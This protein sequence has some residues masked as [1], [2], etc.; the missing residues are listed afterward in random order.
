MA[1]SAIQE[2]TNN[3]NARLAGTDLCNK[4]NEDAG[5]YELVHRLMNS[6]RTRYLDRRSDAYISCFCEKDD[7]LSQW[8]GYSS[9]GGYSI[10]I[11]PKRLKL[12]AIQHSKDMGIEASNVELRFVEYDHAS[13]L[14]RLNELLDLLIARIRARSSQ[15][16]KIHTIRLAENFASAIVK[17]IAKAAPYIKNCG[18]ID[19]HE[20]RLSIYTNSSFN[21]YNFRPGPNGIIPHLTIP[22]GG[23]VK[24]VRV[25]PCR[26]L[27]LQAIA[28]NLMNLGDDVEISKSIL[29]F[30]A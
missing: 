6:V 4:T 23:P 18:F 5:E 16:E 25:G 17:A 27:Q 3:L 10:G 14:T 1:L 12:G 21:N 30:R 20:I 2:R 22:I 8:R 13:W 28:M 7:L 26:D 24:S 11:I 9:P 29:P 19:E 15:L